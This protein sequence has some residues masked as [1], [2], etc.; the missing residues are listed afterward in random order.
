MD[1]ESALLLIS[2]LFLIVGCAGVIT[3]L[4][5]T[6]LILKPLLDG[7]DGEL[8]RK[9]LGGLTIRKRHLGKVT[10]AVA[11]VADAFRFGRIILITEKGQIPFQQPFSSGIHI[12]YMAQNINDC[13]KNMC[14]GNESVELSNYVPV[15]RVTVVM[16]FLMLG[17]PGASDVAGMY[18]MPLIQSNLKVY[19]AKW[20]AEKEKDVI[21]SASLRSISRPAGFPDTAYYPEFCT[22]TLAEKEPDKDKHVLTGT[23]PFKLTRARQYIEP[24]MKKNGWK[25]YD[26][27][28]QLDGM[29][30]SYTNGR[31]DMTYVFTLN[32]DKDNG[33]IVFW[34][35]KN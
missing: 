24:E 26:V 5:T 7:V 4:R 33:C 35:K 9:L 30:M 17:I 32:T 25:L 10:S 28:V 21:L 31:V 12:H 23:T 16:I 15:P 22:Y 8:H 11:E 34:E 6:H 14:R 1:I 2:L 13:I 3:E 27:L 29:F 20:E 19:Y 18:L